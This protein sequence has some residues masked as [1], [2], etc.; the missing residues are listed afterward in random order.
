MNSYTGSMDN[1]SRLRGLRSLT[2]GSLKDQEEATIAWKQNEY[3]WGLLKGLNEGM[4][5]D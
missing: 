5:R 3:S 4:S 1:V 2:E